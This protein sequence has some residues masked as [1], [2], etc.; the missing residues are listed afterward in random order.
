MAILGSGPL[1]NQVHNKIKQHGLTNNIN[2]L[3]FIDGVE[4]F[5]IIKESKVVVHPSVLDSGGMAAGEAMIC[6]L[7]GVSFD[8]QSLKAYYPK[9]MLKTP[10]YDLKA[11]ADNILKLLYDENLYDTLSK[12][13]SDFARKWDWD[14]MAA[15]ILNKVKKSLSE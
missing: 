10:C 8:L 5:R 9:G 2:V 4:K 11:F 6:G 3:G 14:I 12:E 7:P 15:E 13:A 1:S